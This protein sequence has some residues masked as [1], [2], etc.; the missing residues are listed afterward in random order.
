MKRLTAQRETLGL[1]MLAGCFM[2]ATHPVAGDGAKALT[3]NEEM[4]QRLQT[5]AAAPHVA[6]ETIGRSVED[7]PLWAVNLRNPQVVDEPCGVL[8]IGQ[9]H[10]DEPAGAEALIDLVEDLAADPSKLSPNADLWIVPRINPDGAAREARRNAND[11]DLNRDHVVLAQPETRALHRLAQRIRPHLAV[12]CHEFRRDSSDYLDRGWTEWPLI[13]MDTANLV[14]MPDAL[15][16][17]G[18]E[19]CEDQAPRMAAHGF[20][21]QRY[22]VGGCPDPEAAG[23]LRHS[24][25]DPD[26][27]RN[28]LSAYGCLSFIIESGIHRKTADPHADLDQRVAAYRTLLEGFLGDSELLTTA[29]GAAEAARAAAAPQ[30][31]PTNVLWANISPRIT[32]IRVIDQATGRTFTVST[33]A[34]MHD[35]VVKSAV[36]APAAYAIHAD[37]AS[38]FEALLEAHALDYSRLATP[39]FIRVEQVR[40]ER[41]EDTYDAVYHRYAGRQI[42]AVQSAAE[43]EYPA[44]SLVV[45]LPDLSPTDARRAALVLEP[46]QLFGLY[47]WPDFFVLTGSDG[48]LPVAR[49]ISPTLS[50][51]TP[52]VTEELP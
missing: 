43:I 39:T 52:K 23:E 33:P 6:L 19:V 31:V 26:D 36:A 40:L 32:D 15:Y 7:R 41:V 37:A 2:G 24:T 51:F 13:M 38:R 45:S 10:G 47:Q 20:N 21:Y 5:A 18:V 14:I 49:M 3:S 35:R 48:A 12:D 9:Q 27:A 16:R 44:G 46:R 17:L 8:F 22:F 42:T 25:L 34:F 1:L 50:E 30:T 4:A 11:A 29:R 28:A